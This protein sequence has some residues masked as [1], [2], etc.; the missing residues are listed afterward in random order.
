MLLVFFLLIRLICT[1]WTLNFMKISSEGDELFHAEGWTDRRTDMTMLGVAVHSSANAIKT[2]VTT[3][4]TSFMAIYR[5]IKKSLCIWWLQWRDLQ[6][7]FKVSSASLQTYID[8]PYCVLEDTRL[9]L[10]PSVIP[11]YNYVIMVSDWN[12]L[13]YFCVVFVL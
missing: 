13:K 9:T 12:C 1:V 2:V 4:C 7:M 6:V 10:T 3:H 5:L 11:N 8:T